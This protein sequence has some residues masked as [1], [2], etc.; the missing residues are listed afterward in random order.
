MLDALEVPY[1][2]SS[3]CVHRNEAVS[4][5]IVTNAIRA[6][7]IKCSRSGRDEDDAALLIDGH[8][9][10]IVRRA[11]GFSRAGWPGVITKF[12]VVRNGV[13][14]PTKFAGTRIVGAHVTG[15]S[16]QSFGIASSHDDQVLVHN[17]RAGQGDR[18]L[19][20]VAPQV[21]AKIDSSILAKGR[22]GLAGGSVQRV[23]EIHDSGEDSFV[24]SAGPI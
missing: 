8:S 11:A 18:L 20:G 19:L 22:N 9:S 1:P 13:K 5:Q 15:R 24:F 21:F 7:K 4:E 6:I 16:R 2:L 14:R 3:F 17:P 23:N 12:A 10:P